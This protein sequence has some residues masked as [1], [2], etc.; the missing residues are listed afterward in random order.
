MPKGTRNDPIIIPDSPKGSQAIPGDRPTTVDFQPFAQRT[1][2]VSKPGTWGP[3]Q[4]KETMP[5]IPFTP[6]MTVFLGSPIGL[7]EFPG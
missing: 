6:D 3:C 2:N 4:P 1:Q 5:T 7:C